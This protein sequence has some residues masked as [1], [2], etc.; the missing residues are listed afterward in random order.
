MFHREIAFCCK[1]A[2]PASNA[3]HLVVVYNCRIDQEKR[4]LATTTDERVGDTASSLGFSELALAPRPHRRERFE[5]RGEDR[6]DRRDVDRHALVAAV[7]DGVEDRLRPSAVEAAVDDALLEIA[8]RW[9]RL[10]VGLEV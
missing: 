7:V 8:Q 10:V 3:L 1:N 9:P 6:L 2:R 4:E 5:D